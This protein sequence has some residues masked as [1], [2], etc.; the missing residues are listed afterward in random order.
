[1]K[2]GL[3]QRNKTSKTKLLM[4]K[5]VSETHRVSILMCIKFL[6]NSLF[7]HPSHPLLNLEFPINL[8]G[9]IRYFLEVLHNLQKFDA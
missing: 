2:R 5:A 6:K 8:Y 1:M 9:K 7:L 4:F 3:P